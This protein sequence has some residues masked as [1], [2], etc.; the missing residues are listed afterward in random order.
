MV[1]VGKSGAYRNKKLNVCLIEDA[2]A[3]IGYLRGLSQ[4]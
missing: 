1:K 3:A 4:K 2:R